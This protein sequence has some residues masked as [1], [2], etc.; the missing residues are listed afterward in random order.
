M[1]SGDFIVCC[2]LII[3]KFYELYYYNNVQNDV[4]A[5]VVKA[6]KATSAMSW[7]EA[8][9]ILYEAMDNIMEGELDVD[10]DE[11]GETMGFDMSQLQQMQQEMMQQAMQ[12]I[13][14]EQI[15][16]MQQLAMENMQKMMAGMYGNN[17]NTEEDTNK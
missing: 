15:Q 11:E 4:N 17:N 10:D 12:N 13:D 5:V 8:A 9:P 6:M 7:E 2:L 16:K 1:E 3:N 14:M